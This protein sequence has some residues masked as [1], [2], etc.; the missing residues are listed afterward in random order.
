MLQIH[1]P[2]VMKAYNNIEMPNLKWMTVSDPADGR[3]PQPSQIC[4]RSESSSDP[5]PADVGEAQPN[6]HSEWLENDEESESLFNVEEESGGKH[7]FKC[8]LDLP[9]QLFGLILGPR[10]SKKNAIEQNTNTKIFVPGKSDDVNGT[11]VV[12]GNSVRDVEAACR[13]IYHIIDT[14]RNLI[15]PT[16]FL[17]IV[18]DSPGVKRAFENFKKISSID[19]KF[20]QHASKLHL[21]LGMLVLLKDDEKST[22]ASIVEDCVSQNLRDKHGKLKLRLKGVEIMNDDPTAAR[23]LYGDVVKDDAH[24]ELQQQIRQ[25]LCRLN[26]AGL[27][28]QDKQHANSDSVKLHMTIA[29]STF[30]EKIAGVSADRGAKNVNMTF[31]AT[32]ALRKFGDYDFGEQLVNALAICEIGSSSEEHGYVQFSQHFLDPQRDQTDLYI[33]KK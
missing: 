27:L 9:S 16:H 6:Y 22:A 12:R 28:K 13:K 29:N 24:D 11:I 20:L 10:A 30:A 32:D 23:V 19:S 17:G 15:K 33:C 2:P 1:R 5:A 26:L 31:D 25:L 3:K 4:L 8:N 21:T 18:I 7:K 14:N